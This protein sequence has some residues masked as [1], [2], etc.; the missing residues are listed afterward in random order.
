MCHGAA[1]S[2]DIIM[3]G[4]KHK[5]QVIFF[6]EHKDKI[7]NILTHL[8]GEGM[9][10]LVWEKEPGEF[11][12][13]TT[14]SSALVL[15]S[16]H[17][18]KKYKSDFRLRLK[19]EYPYFQI[20]NFDEES[21][22]ISMTALQ[23]KKESS[24]FKDTTPQQV[25]ELLNLKIQ[26]LRLDLSPNQHLE[27]LYFKQCTSEN[28]FFYLFGMP[29]IENKLDVASKS[30][31]K[32]IDLKIEDE[33]AIQHLGHSILKSNYDQIFQKAKVR[34]EGRAFGHEVCFSCVSTPIVK[35]D[36]FNLKIKNEMCNVKIEDWWF[37]IPVPVNIFIFLE[38]NNKKILYLRS[39]TQ[40]S[41]DSVLKLKGKPNESF[42][43]EVKDMHKYFKL[44]SIMSHC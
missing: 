22:F 30:I 25:L 24:F 11:A 23:P 44:Q 39:G 26:P 34:I 27:I 6:C 12:L 18:E 13:Q 10:V 19:N 16:V 40:L 17:Y 2:A 21:S 3:F 35:D 37:H 41:E 15:I 7:K 9:S 29:N 4:E 43:I 38:L 36:D 33:S 32:L 14:N 5:K 31:A 8:E 42:W 1:N 20:I 28:E